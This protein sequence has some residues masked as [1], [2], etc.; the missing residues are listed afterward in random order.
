MGSK[1]KIAILQADLGR[2]L[3]EQSFPAELAQKKKKHR[4]F[5]QNLRQIH[6]NA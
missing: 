6:A 1:I 3:T 2:S 5:I 4:T